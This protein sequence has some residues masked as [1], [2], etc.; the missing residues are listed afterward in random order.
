[1]SGIAAATVA[2]EDRNAGIMVLRASEESA[3]LARKHYIRRL[4]PNERA[5][6]LYTFSSHCHQC[7]R[8]ITDCL[9]CIDEWMSEPA[10]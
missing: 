6:Y 4:E 3:N 7:S 9:D 10:F 1:M 8:P 2:A 5:N